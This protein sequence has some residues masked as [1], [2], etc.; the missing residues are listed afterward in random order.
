[1]TISRRSQGQTPHA[2]LPAVGPIF[3]CPTA[4]P[5]PPPRV[6]GLRLALPHTH[7][8]RCAPG[9]GRAAPAPLGVGVRAHP[10]LPLCGCGSR[11]LGA[12]VSAPTCPSCP[13]SWPT[14]PSPT[15]VPQA[16]RPDCGT[17]ASRGLGVRAGLT[18]SPNHGD[19]RQHLRQAHGQEK[20]KEDR[21]FQQCLALDTRDTASGH[22]GG[23]CAPQA[24]PT[25]TGAGTPP[26]PR[27][28]ARARPALLVGSGLS[29]LPRSLH[30]QGPPPCACTHT[31]PST[32]SWQ[33][34]PPPLPEGCTRPP[35]PALKSCSL[36]TPMGPS[37]P[38]AHTFPL[39]LRSLRTY[40]PGHPHG[41]P[42]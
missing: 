11:E 12:L 40:H 10:G 17:I 16:L 4:C 24:K 5:P 32:P 36:R 20:S 35:T 9:T 37:H 6:P 29:P 13:L 30:P 33:G 41:G 34:S 1:M 18:L 8:P 23:L 42:A 25:A 14:G 15:A 7:A 26:A 38:T 28:G 39:H 22:L 19:V 27:S 3:P 2:L 31:L 21:H